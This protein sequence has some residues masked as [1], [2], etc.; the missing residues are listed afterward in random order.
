MDESAADCSC[1]TEGPVAVPAF[2]GWPVERRVRDTSSAVFRPPSNAPMLFEMFP[3]G[4][5]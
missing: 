1:L 4:A 2:P 3:R 5:M